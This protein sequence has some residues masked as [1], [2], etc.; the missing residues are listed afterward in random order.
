MGRPKGATKTKNYDAIKRKFMLWLVTPDTDRTP[1]T[2]KQFA[3]E[4][5]VYETTLS[6][7]R[8]DPAFFKKLNE[9]VDRQLADEYNEATRSLKRMASHGSF[10]HQKMYFE[11][12]GKYSPTPPPPA[13]VT[14]VVQYGDNKNNPSNAS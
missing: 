1:L 9:L 7:W 8:H 13:Q 2:Q 3:A 5:G 4:N 12:I 11:M 10:N 14:V 6:V